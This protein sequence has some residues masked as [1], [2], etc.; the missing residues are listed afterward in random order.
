MM[1]AYATE[2]QKGLFIGI[3]WAIFNLGA[4]VGGAVAFGNNFHN[5]VSCS[6]CLPS[7]LT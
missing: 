2:S 4:V 6:G 5:E 3:F 7:R 1:M